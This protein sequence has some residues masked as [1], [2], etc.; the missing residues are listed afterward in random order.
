AFRID[1]YGNRAARIIDH[2][3]SL[4]KKSPSQRERVD[5]NGIVHEIF[6]LLQGEATRSS[7]A[8]STELD[9]ELPTIE[10]DRVQLQQVFMNLMLNAI[11]AMQDS[12]GK[13]TIRSQVQDERL[14]FSVIDTGVGLPSENVDQVFSAFFT[15]KPQG[16]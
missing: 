16:S 11:E 2:I 5:V 6:T 4:Y 14:L 15:T 7:V 13:L 3:R 12:G 1:K 8:V 9:A 10:A